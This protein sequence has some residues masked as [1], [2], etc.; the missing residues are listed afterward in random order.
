MG[1]ESCI[2]KM[3]SER[4]REREREQERE[5]AYNKGLVEEIIKKLRKLII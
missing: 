4:E 5:S 2:K 1:V 3:G